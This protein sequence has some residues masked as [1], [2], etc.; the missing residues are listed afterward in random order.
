V[1]LEGDHVLLKNLG[2]E[3]LAHI[4]IFENRGGKIVY[5][6]LDAVS[7]EI[8]E[9]RPALDRN[10]ESLLQDLK[11][12]LVTSGLYE[13]EAEAMIKTW[14]DNWFEEGTRV[15]YILPRQTTDAVLPVTIDPRPAELVR[16]LIG[17][18]EIITPEME[19]SVQQQVILLG[20][21]SSQVR[22]TAM[23]EIRKYGRFSGPILKRILET[24]KDGSIRHRILQLIDKAPEKTD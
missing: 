22:E 23:R 12:M 7:G 18:V 10:V 24:E 4:I 15:F 21:P 2:Q 13:K 8:T 14:R 5:R 17:R 19:K 9:Q 6:I 3:P 11:Q 16:V 1:Q 20:D